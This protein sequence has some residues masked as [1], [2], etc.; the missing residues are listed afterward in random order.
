MIVKKTKDEDQSLHYIIE[1]QIVII[2]N[3]FFIEMTDDKCKMNFIV[4]EAYIMLHYFQFQL[5]IS[6]F[7][8]II[9]TRNIF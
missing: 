7:Q 5:Y 3:A 6:K 2:V 1:I 9:R 8:L 4:H